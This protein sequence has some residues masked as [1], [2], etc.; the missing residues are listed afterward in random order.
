MP[1]GL[2]AC[3]RWFVP[4]LCLV[5]IAACSVVAVRAQQSTLSQS[6]SSEGSGRSTLRIGTPRPSGTAAAPRDYAMPQ[7]APQ[8]SAGGSSQL[9]IRPVAPQPAAR[10]V[11]APVALPSGAQTPPVLALPGSVGTTNSTPAIIPLTSPQQ[12]AALEAEMQRQLPKMV[13]PSQVPADAPL[14]TAPNSAPSP[15]GPAVRPLARPAAQVAHG[16]CERRTRRQR[17]HRQR[18]RA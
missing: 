5:A 4:G 17:R 18:R 14:T 7:S 13:P 16:N 8:Y 1:S 9:V 11:A 3:R 6:S 10:S 15:I 2:R 12:R